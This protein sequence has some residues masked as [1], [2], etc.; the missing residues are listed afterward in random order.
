MTSTTPKQ[1]RVKWF[2]SQSGYGFIEVKKTTED[3][4]FDLFVHHSALVVGGDMFRFLVE[5][6][7]VEYTVKRIQRSGET[8]LTATN[9]TGIGGGPLQCETRHNRRLAE[10]KNYSQKLATQEGSADGKLWQVVKE[11]L[12][13]ET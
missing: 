12:T 10:H 5:G 2:N 4:D 7:Y 11:Q 9:V 8:K 13:E 6:E 3:K 1:G